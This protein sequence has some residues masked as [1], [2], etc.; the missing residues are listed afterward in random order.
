M[1][2]AY[3]QH[4]R[5]ILTGPERKL[6]R[7][8][9]RLRAEGFH[10]RRQVPFGRFVLDF[11][12]HRERLVIEVEGR[13]HL[14]PRQRAY[15]EART[16]AIEAR[17]YLVVRYSND[18]VLGNIGGVMNELLTTLHERRRIKFTALPPPDPALPDRPPLD[19]GGRAQS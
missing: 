10:L 17:G 6:W 1:T 12:S 9:R 2:I 8:L 18:R 5:R 16:R 14:E 7:A 15:D 11:A 19:G 4:L 13:S 3:A